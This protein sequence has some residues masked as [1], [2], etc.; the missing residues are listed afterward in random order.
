MVVLLL[1]AGV[2][3]FGSDSVGTLFLHLEAPR[4]LRNVTFLTE[5]K[6]PLRVQV[7]TQKDV[8]HPGEEI[9]FQIVL[10]DTGNA[11]V[12]VRVLSD[13]R[14]IARKTWTFQ[15]IPP[16]SVCYRAPFLLISG[17]SGPARVAV[18]NT[19]GRR[20]LERDVVLG[21]T[22]K[23]PLPLVPGVYVWQVKQDRGTKQGRWVVLR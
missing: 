15:R 18:F 8:W 6:G 16:L 14:E 1:I 7:P 22:V 20:V 12:T 4:P 10:K 2:F 11:T 17:G 3:T 13:G 21:D 23:I 5:A 19:L 9:P